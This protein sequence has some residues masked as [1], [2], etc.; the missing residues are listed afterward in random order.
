MY[1]GLHVKYPSFLLDINELVFSWRIL[2]KHSKIKF[3]ENPSVGAAAELSMRTD[4]QTERH[5][6][7][8]SRFWHYCE[9]P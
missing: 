7:A 1:I 2:E 5:D 8:N 6:E 9:R 4:G 3:H